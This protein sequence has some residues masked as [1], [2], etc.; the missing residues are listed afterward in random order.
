MDKRATHGIQRGVHVDYG[1]SADASYMWYT[2]QQDSC[3][4]AILE[5]NGPK[6]PKF[7]SLFDSPSYSGKL[8]FIFFDL[9]VLSK[10]FKQIKIGKDRC[11]LLITNTY[12]SKAPSY[13][14]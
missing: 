1:L 6:Q 7:H 11:D 12:Y 13:N 5:K 4:Q 9:N 2:K 8:V 14:V 3:P 10:K